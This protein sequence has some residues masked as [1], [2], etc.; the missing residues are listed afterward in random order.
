M[1]QSGF[2]AMLLLIATQHQSGAQ[3]RSAAAVAAI[4]KLGGKVEVD[5]E[6]PG[7]PV[8]VVNLSQTKITDDAIEH[9]KSLA[10]L[11]ELYL[12]DTG[13]TDAGVARLAG[14]K[15]LVFLQMGRTKITDK[16]LARLEGLSQLRELLLDSTAISD[17]GLAYVKRLASSRDALFES[18]ENWRRRYR[19]PEG[20]ST[21]ADVVFATHQHHEQ[22]PRAPQ[23]PPIARL[24][25]SDRHCGLGRQSALPE[26]D[27]QAQSPRPHWHAGHS[28][29]TQG[30]SPK[31]SQGQDRRQRDT[32]GELNGD[33]DCP[34]IFSPARRRKNLRCSS[35]KTRDDLAKE[36][37]ESPKGRVF[38][39]LL[40][41]GFASGGLPTRAGSSGVWVT[42]RL[43]SPTPRE[44]QFTHKH[45]AATLT[46]GRLLSAG[47]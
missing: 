3:E 41:L 26:K 35:S 27:A 31:L 32:D 15:R 29:R 21:P 45:G 17:A 13:I 12:N 22:R 38:N 8:I 19:Q 10:D 40:P 16:G 6:A 14:L 30:A 43:A 42:R 1:R 23:G 46:C 44:Q 25:G 2:L 47:Y 11:Q 4:E 9:L 24:A 39:A 20:R 36:S 7:K 37:F 33:L 5:R 18:H 34:C 28:R